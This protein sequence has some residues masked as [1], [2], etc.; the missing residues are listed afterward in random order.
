MFAKA[1]FT[2]H[3]GGIAADQH[4]LSGNKRV[5]VIEWELVRV[6]GDGAKVICY[7]GSAHETEKIVR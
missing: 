6:I 2:D 7:L 5:M 4:R 1:S 3:G